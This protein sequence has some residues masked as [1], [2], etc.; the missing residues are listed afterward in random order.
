M[1]HS[2]KRVP[3]RYFA[4]LLGALSVQG[5]DTSRLLQIAHIEAGRFE[6]SDGMLLP[7]EV[8][9]FLTAAYHVTGRTDLGF[10]MGRLIKLNSHDQLGYGMLSCRDLDHLLRLTSRYYHFIIELFS[11]RYRRWTDHGEVVFSPVVAMPLRAM[12][13]LIEVIGVSVQNQL[14]ML[15]G[16]EGTAVD[17][18]MGMP[19]PAHQ[20]R[21][22]ELLPAR[23]HFDER[24]MPSIRLVIGAGLLELPLPMASPQVVEQIEERLDSLKRR[25][26]PHGGW[27]EYI[28][29][30][31]RETQGQQVT[32]EDIARRM[33]ISARTIDR[34]LKK[35][36]LQFR[37]LSQQVRFERASAL[38][39]QPGATVSAVAEQL[40]FSDA[41][42]FARAF[43]RHAG[44]APSDFK[45]RV[46]SG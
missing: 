31:L 26:A 3:V 36:N 16:P 46:E 13:F 30:L 15:L 40:G 22:L 1:T 8:E 39:A 18:H 4:L 42:N 37:E 33:N 28:T 6:R 38:L 10:E 11:M 19:A 29:M 5:V 43:K 20:A 7:S 9:A 34:N 2:P 27:G 21:Y 17:I 23:F 45:Q 44:V 35:E 24:A 25:P 32:L 41:A 14:K 12:R